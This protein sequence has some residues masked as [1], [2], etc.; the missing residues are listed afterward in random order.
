[1][2]LSTLNKRLNNSYY[3]YADDCIRDITE[4]LSTWNSQEKSAEDIF[5]MVQALEK[6]L[7]FKVRKVIVIVLI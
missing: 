1:M 7:L 2:N 6:L 3:L 4:M 5:P